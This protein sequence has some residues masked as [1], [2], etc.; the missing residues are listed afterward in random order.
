MSQG[1]H[2][3]EISKTV[4]G[5]AFSNPDNAPTNPLS[6]VPVTALAVG[7]QKVVAGQLQTPVV[8]VLIQNPV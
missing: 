6:G 7:S 5:D 1:P 8:T 4:A 3:K 2:T